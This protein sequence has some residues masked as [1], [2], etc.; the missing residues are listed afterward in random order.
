MKIG[1]SAVTATFM[2]VTV[3]G[4]TAGTASSRP[5][6]VKDE[7]VTTGEEEGVA[8]RAVLADGAKGLTTVVEGGKFEI[9]EHGAKVL[10][11]S[12][13]GEVVAVVPLTFEVSGH[14][15]SVAHQIGEEGRKLVLAPRVGAKEIGEM[16]PI[17]SMAR[18]VTELN[19]NVVGMVV[20]GLLGGLIGAV[21]GLG[22]FSIVT[23]PIGMAVGAVAGGYIMGGQPF[24][25]AVM[26]VVNGEG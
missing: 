22:F 6:E 1:V 3:L 7:V 25:E 17:S 18:L 16:R 21:I 14:A 11:K 23:G 15:V 5:T 4:V 20:G 19:R 2:A 10:L 26:A 24:A 12:R 13:M 9:A 8:Y